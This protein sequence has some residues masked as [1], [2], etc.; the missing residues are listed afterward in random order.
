[1]EASNVELGK[2]DRTESAREGSRWLA[3]HHPVGEG[4]ADTRAELYP[5]RVEA[6]GH[7]QVGGEGRTPED[8]LM[9]DGV[10]VG[11]VDVLL[12]PGLKRTRRKWPL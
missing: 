8:G 2:V 3:V 1:V 10:G 5:E 4:E 6:R 7:P 12:E 9:V 11:A